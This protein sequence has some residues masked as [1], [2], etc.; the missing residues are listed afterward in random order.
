[1]GAR[2]GGG[3]TWGRLAL[4]IAAAS[5]SAADISFQALWLLLLALRAAV[6]AAAR[7]PAAMVHLPAPG[8][9]AISAWCAAL[10][11]VPYLG[12]ARRWVRPAAAVSLA[13][14]MGL[15]V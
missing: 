11:L 12:C 10:A 3:T 7:M 13:L 2:G 9:P 5:V 15:S 6:W 14:A 1:G 8:W 4:L